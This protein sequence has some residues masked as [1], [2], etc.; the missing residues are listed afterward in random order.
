MAPLEEKVIREIRADKEQL[1]LSNYALLYEDNSYYTQMGHACYANIKN[2]TG[3]K[4]VGF[5]DCPGPGSV[6]H[7]SSTKTKLSR[8]L[9]REWVK[10]ITKHS[11]YAPIY[12]SKSIDFSIYQGCAYDVS[13]S[14]KLVL[15]AAMLMRYMKERPGTIE[16][17]SRIRPYTSNDHI[18]LI[19]GHAIHFVDRYHFRMSANWGDNHTILHYARFHKSSLKQFI[20]FQMKEE[21]VSKPM[22]ETLEY[23]GLDILFGNVRGDPARQL[24]F[25]STSEFL[26]TTTI[27]NKWGRESQESVYHINDI[28]TLVPMWEKENLSDT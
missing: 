7:P 24:S 19:F 9:A 15:S 14:P 28:P 23:R 11:H 26:R 3:K 13:F 8:K 17:W 10:W 2:P 1:H 27:T 4:I 6:R 5:V 21:A 16:G 20:S 25:A 22:T 18:A 12:R